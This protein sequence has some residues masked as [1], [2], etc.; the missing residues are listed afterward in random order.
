V[1]ITAGSGAGQELFE[2]SDMDTVRIYVQVS[3]AFTAQLHPG[4]KATFELPQ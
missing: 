4:L 2:I 3:Q 1:L